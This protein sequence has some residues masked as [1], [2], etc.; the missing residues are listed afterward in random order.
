[1]SS[2][3]AYG[4]PALPPEGEKS[5]PGL[6]GVLDG[7]RFPTGHR[8][9]RGALL[10]DLAATV[11]AM[12]VSLFPLGQ[13][14]T[15][16]RRPA[17]ARSVPVRARRGRCRRDGVLRPGDPAGASRPGDAVRVGGLGCGPRA[18]RPDQ[19]RLGGPGRPGAGRWL[20]RRTR[21]AKGMSSS[22]TRRKPTAPGTPAAPSSRSPRGARSRGRGTRWSPP[23]PPL[24]RS[25][26][27]TI[28]LIQDWSAAASSVA[29]HPDVGVH[30]VHRDIAQERRSASPRHE[31]RHPLLQPLPALRPLLRRDGEDRRVAEPS[32][33][34]G[35]PGAG[36]VAQDALE[37]GAD[38][39]D[40]GP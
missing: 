1:M 28:I 9:V 34:A 32:V 20:L 30:V 22:P 10:T 37:A 24:G 11:L 33:L 4:L 25:G 18:V 21:P 12:P 8:V 2:Y 17:H 31:P 35:S 14:G 3:G 5:R 36:P 29:A 16:R 23:P 19:Q 38:A 6:H 7:L 15:L 39:L 27:G 13:R 40:R 26:S